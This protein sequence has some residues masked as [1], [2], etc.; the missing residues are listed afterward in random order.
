MMFDP[1]DLLDWGCMVGVNDGVHWL[2]TCLIALHFAGL[3]LLYMPQKAVAI[4]I[5]HHF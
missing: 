5:Y 1:N 4:T 3:N 2:N